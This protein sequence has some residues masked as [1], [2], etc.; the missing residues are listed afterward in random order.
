M[1]AQGKIRPMD[2]AAPAALLGGL[3]PAAFM[4]RYWQRRPLL[5]RAAWPGA[6]PPAPRA[7][8][9]A[10]AARDDVESRLVTRFDRRW[11]LA[12]GPFSRRALPPLSRRGWT[13]LL[14]GLDLH[15][16]AARAMLETFRFVGDARLDDL[17]LSYAT[18]GGGVGPHCDAYDVFLL[19]VHGRRRWRVGWVADP[20]LVEGLPVKIL[21]RFEPEQDWVLEP[22]DMLYLPPMWGHDGIAIGECMTCSVG[23]R[24]PRP[25]ALARELLGQLAD[26]LPDRDE[27]PWHDRG[28]EA[29]ADPGRIPPALRRL[30][31]A[32]LRRAIDSPGAIDRALGTMLTEPKPQVWFDPG[33]PLPH[34]PS[35][36]ALDRRTRMMY[37]ATRVFINGEVAACAGRDRR[38]LRRLA[39]R[40][41]L[42]AA[43]AAQLSVA[44]RQL[45]SGWAEAGWLHA[46]PAQE[47]ETK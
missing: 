31:G 41:H 47:G 7:Q 35:A 25:T 1:I 23:F 11:Q 28:A 24:A 5:V 32:A 46:L 12:H 40:R 8:L 9:L 6:A 37:D 16:D 13:L 33:L 30:A 10:L 39:D 45:L 38:W 43:A 18:D 17:M 20:A 15:L 21:R 29:M 14:Q 22:G 42:D 4:R 2:T 3:T 26:A 36:L 27:A 34:E 44:A 19:Q